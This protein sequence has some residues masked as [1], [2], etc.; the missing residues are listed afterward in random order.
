M[1]DTKTETYLVYQSGQYSIASAITI[2][3][4]LAG[5]CVVLLAQSI[6]P[7]RVTR[8]LHE[9][10]QKELALEMLGHRV[11]PGPCLDTPEIKNELYTSVPEIHKLFVVYVANNVTGEAVHGYVYTDK[12]QAIEIA[13]GRG[14]NGANAAVVERRGFIFN[15]TPYLL[16]E[17]NLLP[18]NGIPDDVLTHKADALFKLTDAEKAALNLSKIGDK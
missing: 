18:L 13:K 5:V 1:C 8:D 17:S 2:F 6:T 10:L 14:S 3:T 11:L 15:M 9:E 4:F 7:D 12:S 16:R